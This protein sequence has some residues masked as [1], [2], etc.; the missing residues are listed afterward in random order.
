LLDLK[1]LKVLAAVARCGSFSAAAYAMDYSQPAVSNNI[2]R[3]ELEVGTRLF[4]RG[5]GGGVRLTPAGE[6]LLGHAHTL[7]GQVANAEE[8]LAE[9]IGDGRRTVRLGSFATAGQIIAETVG[10]FRNQDVSFTLIEG[11]AA[12]LTERLKGRQL[13]LA[14]MFDDPAHPIHADDEVELRY[15]YLDP[16]LIAVPARHRLSNEDEIA[17]AALEREEWIEGAGR[18]SPCS[19]ILAGLCQVAGFEPRVSFNSGNYQ[20]VLSLVGAG[21]GVALVPE[22]A[23]FGLSVDPMV[24]LCRVRSPGVARRIAVGVLRDR[25]RPPAVE[26]ALKEIERTFARRTAP[27]RGP[28]RSIDVAYDPSRPSSG[29]DRP[30]LTRLGA[31]DGQSRESRNSDG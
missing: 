15:L 26:A 29:E 27:P 8:E 14:L 3:L 21:V 19:L 12:E 20:T 11:E 10:R 25:F 6:L 7:M 30:G 9:L 18:E 5:R 22:L 13:D 24:A 17:I 1:R 2:N 4:D 23:I 31:E 16:M 28:D